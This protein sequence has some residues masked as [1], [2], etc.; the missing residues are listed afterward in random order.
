M[1]S[2]TNS[3]PLNHAVVELRKSADLATRNPMLPQAAR[4]TVAG[5]VAIVGRLARDAERQALELQELRELVKPCPCEEM[6]ALPE[7]D[8]VGAR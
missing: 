6:P 7:I 8:L 4:D 3:C 1:T 5:L 2:P